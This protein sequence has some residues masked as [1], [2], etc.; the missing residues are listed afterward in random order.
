MPP[1]ARHE[2]E[3][4]LANVLHEIRIANTN[5]DQRDQATRARLAALEHSVN[6]LM[7]RQGRPGGNGLGDVDA[8]ASAIGL[9]E[10]KHFAAQ[11]KM[12]SG[13]PA[14]NFSSEQIAEAQ[15]AI[16]GLRTLMHSTSIDQVPHDQRKAL[17]AFSLGSQFP[18]GARDVERNSVVPRE[19][20][21]HC[22]ADAQH[23]H[24]QRRD[25]IHGRQRGVGRCGVGLRELVLR[26]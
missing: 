9:L 12:D 23:Q 7:K 24:L 4:L 13:L 15:M 3:T 1:E 14:P 8:R 22:R 16:R 6:D 19:R 10:Q 25:Q 11:T 18:A 20:D 2:P 17:S 21:R 26:K 5:I